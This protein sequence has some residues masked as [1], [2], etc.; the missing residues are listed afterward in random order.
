MRTK[1]E[2]RGRGRKKGERGETDRRG[3]RGGQILGETGGGSGRNSRAQEAGAIAAGA[4]GT[5]I[6]PERYFWKKK[7]H[8]ICRVKACST[9]N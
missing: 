5:A 2:K 3:K 7:L 8:H 1:K 9:V 6:S 4:H